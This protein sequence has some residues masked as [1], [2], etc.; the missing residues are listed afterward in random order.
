MRINNKQ[1]IDFPAAE[2][3]YITNL[4]KQRDYAGAVGYYEDNC[5]TIRQTGGLPAGEILYQVTIAYASLSNYPAALKTARLAQNILSTEGDSQHLADL[6]MALGGILRDTGDIKEAEKAFRDAESIFRRND[7]IDGQSRAL[8]QLAGLFF[9]QNDY[10]NSLSI[11]MDAITLAHKLGDKKKLAFM[12]GNIGRIYAFTGNFAES[13]K[14]L[15]VNIDLSTELSD[16]AEVA[17]ACL[18]LGYNHIQEG[19]YQKAEISLNEAYHH[20]ISGNNRKDEVIYYTYLGELK[21]RCEMYEEAS[22]ILHKTLDMANEI[23]PQSTL[24]GR[25]M[26]HL[27]ELYIRTKKYRSASRFAVSAITIM[28]R[29]GDKVE[30]SALCKIKAIVAEENNRQKDARK[31]FVKAID[32]SG[33]SGVRFEHADILVAAGKS[34]LFSPREKMTY[35]F[36][37]E[38]FYNKNRLKRKLTKVERLIAAVEYTSSKN[39]NERTGQ[40]FGKTA[41][42]DFLTVCP[43]IIRFKKQLP[44]I[45][46]SELPVIITGETGVGKDHMARYFHNISRPEGPFV[47]INCASIP[48]T[49]LESELF[50]FKKGT[51][52][53]A[54]ANK[55]GLFLAAD[56]GVLFLDEIGDMPPTL[57]TK[58]LGVLEK[59]K[60]LPLGS[61]QEIDIDIKLITATNKNLKAMVN[62]GTFR[63]DL[64]YR[65]SGIGFEIP[66]LRNRKEDIPLLLDYF[67][68][69]SSLL[70]TGD[71]IPSELLANF[72]KYDW[73]GNTRELANKV[74]KLEI[75]AEMVA[76]GDLVELSRSIFSIDTP[77]INSNLFDQVE[78]FERQLITE[79]MLAAN[80]NKSKAARLLGIHEATVRT[81]IKRYG[82]R[83]EGGLPN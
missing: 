7:C 54:D 40:T 4:V 67:M 5:N 59:R 29:A 36:R 9:K 22:E 75:M 72:I 17:R 81:K 14:H 53:G 74:K 62:E 83:L 56:N 19:E 33:E 24:A 38:E 30:C 1:G 23:S 28:E 43:D 42:N 51:F 71:N 2:Q 70:E 69:K 77:E 49:L 10:K 15:Q 44:M 6:F 3:H 37:A 13:N 31:Y 78:Q 21:Y 11:L 12:M 47:T 48:E 35:L 57:Q 73:P 80:G 46:R 50:G 45:A 41:E 82:I 66:P 60:V 65:I 64:Y 61:T 16:W 39:D 26:R 34:G 25:V 32:L 68:R 76:E 79:A 52:T 18:S 58:L 8:N 63:R 27:A 55:P 20:I